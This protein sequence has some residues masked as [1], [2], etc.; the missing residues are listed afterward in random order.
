MSIDVQLKLNSFKATQWFKDGDHPAVEINLPFANGAG[1]ERRG[2]FG[3]ETVYDYDDQQSEIFRGMWVVEMFDG[4]H[5]YD[6]DDF[7]KLF[8]ETVVEGEI[9]LTAQEQIRLAGDN[10]L[11]RE[12]DIL[13]YLPDI[14]AYCA[15][16]TI[17]MDMFVFRMLRLMIH[18]DAGVRRAI[19][20]VKKENPDLG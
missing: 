5:L 11:V 14:E 10:R 13:N 8:E 3:I 20:I 19:R 15:S 6:E 1:R 12:K 7:K 2:Y 17:G 9:M 18:T 16:H 4:I